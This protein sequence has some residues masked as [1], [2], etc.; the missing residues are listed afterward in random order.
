VKNKPKGLT[1]FKC[2]NQEC[3]HG[4]LIAGIYVF[5]QQCPLCKTHKIFPVVTMT[6]MLT[7]KKTPREN[8]LTKTLD[9]MIVEAD[10][11][12]DFFD[13]QL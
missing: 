3:D 10:L 11:L 5:A 9:N 6:D 1:V 13:G 8:I 4:F 2:S 7:S 12:Y